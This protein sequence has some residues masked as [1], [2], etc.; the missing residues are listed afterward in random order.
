MRSLSDDGSRLRYFM[1]T[2]IEDMLRTT[3]PH[4]RVD[5]FGSSSNGFGWEGSDLD[6]MLT[7]MHKKQV[8]RG[9]FPISFLIISV[10]TDY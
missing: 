2:L 3:L 7:L 1:C 8:T 4:C 9:F 10:N 6:M 5:P